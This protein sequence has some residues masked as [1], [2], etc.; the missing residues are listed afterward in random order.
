MLG[1]IATKSALTFMCCNIGVNALNLDENYPTSA[2]LRNRRRLPEEK[3]NTD[4]GNEVPKKDPAPGTTEGIN[5]AALGGV[6]VVPCLFTWAV[7]TLNEKRLS[8]LSE[9]RDNFLEKKANFDDAQDN[10][11]AFT[12]DL[13]EQLQ[14]DQGILAKVNLK[15][16]YSPEELERHDLNLNTEE[17]ERFQLLKDNNAVT[18]IDG[19]FALDMPV[20]G[21]SGYY[22]ELNSYNMLISENNRNELVAL[23]NAE[24]DLIEAHKLYQDMQVDHIELALSM[25]LIAIAVTV[26]LTAF[27]S[28]YFREV[29]PVS[30]VN[31]GLYFGLTLS[32]CGIA[33]G[34]TCNSI[35]L[36]GGYEHIMGFSILLWF[37]FLFALLQ[38]KEIVDFKELGKKC[39]ER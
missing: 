7:P 38:L 31:L 21:Q 11:E 29:S 32:G 16:H 4:S 6:G 1:L 2:F 33:I 15:L 10:T 34:Q 36:A 8:D 5:I 19:Q 20:G 23:S 28:W 27:F 22:N 30:P 39:M 25:A 3:D 14:E 9:K 18:E 12:S 26:L 17:S 35:G 13:A 24:T 37:V